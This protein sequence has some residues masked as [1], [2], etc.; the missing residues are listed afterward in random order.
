MT[1]NTSGHTGAGS[2]NVGDTTGRESILSLVREGMDVYH[3]N[4]DRIGSVDFV[5]F[6][7]ASE[8]QQDFGTGPAEPAPADDPQMREDS[9]IDNIAEAFYPDEVPE[10]LRSRLLMNGYVR[11]D[12]SGLFARDRFIMPDQISGVSGDQ[13]MLNVTRDQ[14]A[15]R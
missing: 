14:L 10:T 3:V 12:T 5:H 7:A 6:G 2:G 8:T 13:V 9:I 15:T 4:N 11:L 1:Q